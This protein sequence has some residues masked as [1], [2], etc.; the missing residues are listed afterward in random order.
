MW[1]LDNLGKAS[2]INI[3]KSS[4]F[5]NVSDMSWNPKVPHIISVASDSGI[6]SIIDLRAKKEI[7]TLSLQNE[8][9]RSSVSC[10]EWHPEIVRI[11]KLCVLLIFLFFS[12]P[13]L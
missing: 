5:G 7:T 1:D 10:I 3:E 4:K 6:V 12:L 13:T 2:I 11:F 9:N 8:N